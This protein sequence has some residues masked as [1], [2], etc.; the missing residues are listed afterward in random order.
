MSGMNRTPPSFYL[1]NG[2][3]TYIL[4][5]YD[6]EK[7]LEYVSTSDFTEDIKLLFNNFSDG[8][9]SLRWYPF[10]VTN[11]LSDYSRYET[12]NIGELSLPQELW[13]GNLITLNK[14]TKTLEHI[15]T[16]YI[17]RS[18]S[19]LDYPPYTFMEIHLPYIGFRP[20]DVSECI[21][22][23]IYVFYAFDYNTGIA[24]AFVTNEYQT[25]LSESDAVILTAETKIGVDIP[26]TLYNANEVSKN[27]LA[28]GISIAGGIVN[29]AAATI[30]NPVLG[31]GS[32]IGLAS[33]LNSFLEANQIHISKGSYNDSANASY[34][35]IHCF[36]RQR[37]TSVV[38]PNNMGEYLGYPCRETLLLSD[39]TGFTRTY[40]CH[41]E[42]IEATKTEIDLIYEALRNGVIL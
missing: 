10:I 24:T 2:V 14:N 5:N 8:I 40:E 25:T 35:D 32:G 28:T 11:S 21:G 27:N 42:N 36:I 18:E 22:R 4:D 13:N 38:E 26:I 3:R 17:P 16:I 31:A 12:I 19:Y 9:V 34:G 39:C 30:I 29:T 41:I 33:Q 1:D 23:N 20:I 15:A 7:F 37:K 6:V